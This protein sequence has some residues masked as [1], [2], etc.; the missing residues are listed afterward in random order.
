[1]YTKER[2][3]SFLCILLSGEAKMLKEKKA[4]T[5]EVINVSHEATPCFTLVWKRGITMHNNRGSLILKEGPLGFLS[6]LIINRSKTL[7]EGNRNKSVV[8]APSASEKARVVVKA[9]L[10][11]FPHADEAVGEAREE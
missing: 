6:E 4:N 9:G 2:R 5:R 10:A 11:L 8:K 7:G 3:I 1:M